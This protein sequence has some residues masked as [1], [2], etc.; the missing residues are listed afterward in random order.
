[1][2][3]PHFL[4]FGRGLLH[5]HAD[6]VT[7]SMSTR[8]FSNARVEFYSK[9]IIKVKKRVFPKPQSPFFFFVW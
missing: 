3:S 5:F 1:M 9:E 4:E 6:K 8:A 7:F 2:R